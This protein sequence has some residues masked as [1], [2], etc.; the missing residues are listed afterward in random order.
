MCIRPPGCATFST[1]NA[2]ASVDHAAHSPA[3]KLY[4]LETLFFCAGRNRI[5]QLAPLKPYQNHKPVRRCSRTHLPVQVA[6]GRQSMVCGAVGITGHH[7]ASLGVRSTAKNDI[8]APHFTYR[9]L[10]GNRPRFTAMYSRYINWHAR[11][12]R[13]RQY[14]LK[15]CL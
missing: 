6:H 4:F 8:A 5:I 3:R 12:K 1:G 2:P 11:C 15:F 13:P 14:N 7:R 10:R 9:I